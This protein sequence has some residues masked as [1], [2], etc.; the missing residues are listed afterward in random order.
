MWTGYLVD[1]EV[2]DTY[3]GDYTYR[4]V[5]CEYDPNEGYSIFTHDY[6]AK[7]TPT[8]MITDPEDVAYY[9]NQINERN[10]EEGENNA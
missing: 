5:W 8:E 3:G 6:G 4:D 10:R 7:E 9:M 2:V 1:G